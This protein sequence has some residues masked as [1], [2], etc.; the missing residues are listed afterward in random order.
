MVIGGYLFIAF[1]VTYRLVPETLKRKQTNNDD[2]EMGEE[3]LTHDALIENEIENDN[4]NEIEENVENEV[5][6]NKQ[7]QEKALA[8][9]KSFEISGE[10]IIQIGNEENEEEEQDDDDDGSV[11]FKNDFLDT[12]DWSMKKRLMLVAKVSFFKKSFSNF[13]N[14]NQ[15]QNKNRN[16]NNFLKNKKNR[17]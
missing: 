15:N 7:M 9:E 17:H 13:Q 4:E 14:T 6:E 11:S 10:E 2:T 8:I 16:S 12:S 3:L 5:V 1:I